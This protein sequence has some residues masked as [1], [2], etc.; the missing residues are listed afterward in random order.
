MSTKLSR[1]QHQVLILWYLVQHSLTSY[2]KLI[3]HFGH[4]DTAIHPHNIATW[5]TLKIHKNHIQRALDFQHPQQQQYFQNIIDVICK[6]CDFVCTPLDEDY[7]KQLLHYS[8]H[9]PILFG[10]GNI[11]QLNTPQISIVGSRKASKAGLQ[12]SYDFAY[13]LA[14]AG[15][16]ITSGLATG[17]DQAAHDAA[18][19]HYRTI[20]V[21][22]TGIDTTYPKANHSLRQRILEHGGAVITEFL[23]STPPLQHHFPRRNRIVSGLSLAV[24]VTQA[25][26][27][28]GSLIT[29]KTAAEQGKLI[30]AIP[31][32]IYDST[33]HGC[34]QLIREGATLVDHPEQILED[35]ALPAHWYIK[36]SEPQISH[37][38]SQTGPAVAVHLQ[39]TLNALSWQGQDIDE[40]ATKTQLTTSTLIANLMELEL[41]GHC[42]QQFGL[43]SRQA[44]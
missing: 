30:F 13:F 36:A 6:H 5:S 34:H 21:M 40:L 39:S 32:H 38:Q 2:H 28:S 26:L 23:P 20:A 8:D 31:G 7:P 35:I 42:I 15:F 25:A 27:K 43:Y 14:E 12:I 24:L 37:K 29:A 1:H 19:K 9:P 44:I 4:V 11:K 17:I 18:L 3:D 41:E 22:G 16:T 33:Y 10:Q